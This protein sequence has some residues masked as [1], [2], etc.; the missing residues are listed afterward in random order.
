MKQAHCRTRVGASPGV[1]RSPGSQFFHHR[2][3]GLPTVVSGCSPHVVG[4]SNLNGLIRVARSRTSQ[5]ASVISNVSRFPLK[6]KD[7]IVLSRNLG[8][9]SVS[10]S[11]RALHQPPLV[12]GPCRGSSPQWNRE[13][14]QVE[15]VVTMTKHLPPPPPSSRLLLSPGI[16]LLSAQMP[17]SPLCGSVQKPGWAPV[18]SLF[19]HPPYPNHHQ[20]LLPVLVLSCLSPL[21]WGTLVASQQGP[22]IRSWWLP[23]PFMLWPDRSMSLLV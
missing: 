9:V 11:P 17:L 18:F 3:R 12:P 16:H 19:P 20:V 14:P 10:C 22:A 8:M 1:S 2:K 23:L 15:A 13:M 21:A 6:A 4:T 5:V 7:P